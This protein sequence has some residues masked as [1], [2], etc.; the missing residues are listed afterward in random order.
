MAWRHFSLTGNCRRVIS[1]TETGDAAV[2]SNIPCTI[3]SI[4]STGRALLTPVP[5]G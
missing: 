4:L 1:G 3:D 2:C 5:N